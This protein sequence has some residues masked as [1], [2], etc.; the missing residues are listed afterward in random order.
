M[1]EHLV[2]PDFWDIPRKT[3]AAMHEADTDSC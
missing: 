2:E 1:E 3:A